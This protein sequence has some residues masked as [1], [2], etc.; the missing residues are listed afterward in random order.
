MIPQPD[1]QKRIAHTEELIAR[2]EERVRKHQTRA[3]PGTSRMV[4]ELTN[5][6]RRY[7]RDLRNL[8]ARQVNP[9]T[10]NQL[11]EQQTQMQQAKRDATDRS[12]ELPAKQDQEP[13]KVASQQGAV[14]GQ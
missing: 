12:G 7:R 2:A 14:A 5:N 10:Q 8:L 1:F 4:H 6:I 3:K 13:R 11:R 9:P